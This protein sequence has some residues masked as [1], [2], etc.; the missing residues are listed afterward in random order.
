MTPP[1][2]FGFSDDL[3]RNRADRVPIGQRVGVVI[4][5]R[6]TGPGC[7]LTWGVA[8]TPTSLPMC[9]YVRAACPRLVT[10]GARSWA[11]LN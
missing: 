9:R 10:F 6:L 8:T 5:D 7:E 3:N 4:R 11:G 2:T 1:P